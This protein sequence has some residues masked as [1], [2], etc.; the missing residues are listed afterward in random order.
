VANPAVVIIV[1]AVV[2]VVESLG[3]PDDGPGRFSVLLHGLVCTH[4]TKKMD[5]TAIT[6]GKR[7]E[8]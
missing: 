1:V 5:V 3:H 6:V 4:L 2:V 7:N 8:R